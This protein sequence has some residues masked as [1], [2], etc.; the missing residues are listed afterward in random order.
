MSCGRNRFIP[1]FARNSWPALFAVLIGV[2]RALAKGFAGKPEWMFYEE[3]VSGSLPE[4]M[5]AFTRLKKDQEWIAGLAFGGA[6]LLKTL[7]LALLAF[8]LLRGFRRFTPTALVTVAG[9]SL[10]MSVVTDGARDG[11]A[12]HR[13]WPAQVPAH[14]PHRALAG[15]EPVSFRNNQS[16]RA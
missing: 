11:I 1:G 16:L 3:L 14:N 4:V 5:W 9:I 6:I 15:A 10:G 2:G 12:S 13:G 8:T 7:P